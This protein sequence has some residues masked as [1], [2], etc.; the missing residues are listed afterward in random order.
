M[1]KVAF[2]RHAM[3]KFD[4]LK[5]HGFEVTRAQVEELLLEP[6]KVISDEGD[7][8]IAQKAITERQ[9][10][11][12]VY[13]VEGEAMIVITFYPGRRDRYEG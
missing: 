4:L 2:T 1:S 11:R 5:R 10:L 12:E 6:E 7:K 9:V 13:R 8:F 3:V